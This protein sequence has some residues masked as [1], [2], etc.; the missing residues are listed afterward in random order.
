M[1]YRAIRASRRAAV[2]AVAVAMVVFA[3]ADPAAG[4]IVRN[5][6]ANHTAPAGDQGFSHVGRFGTTGG[7]NSG[8]Y[9]GH[10]G[11]FNWVLTAHHNDTPAAAFHIAGHSLNQISSQRIGGGTT[12]LRLVKL[13]GGDIGLNAL[14]IR[15]APLVTTTAITMVGYGVAAAGPEQ[16][17]NEGGGPALNGFDWTSTSTRPKLWGNNDISAVGLTVNGTSAFRAIFQDNG[18]PNQA[19]FADKDSGSGVF[20][21]N[22]GVWELA[23]MAFAIGQVDPLP[24]RDRNDFSSSVYGDTSAM[25]DLTQYR[26]AIYAA[27]PEPASVALLAAGGAALLFRGR[28]RRRA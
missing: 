28:R 15:S 17:F 26:D 5:Q 12:D 22:G 10:I 14:T 20:I 16:D 21:D 6:Q 8:T 18:D 2:L 19:T 23:G 3:A 25:V 9:L 27:I 4:L 7:P 24:P 1:P 11:G 13:D